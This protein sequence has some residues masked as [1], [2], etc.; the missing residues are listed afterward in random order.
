VNNKEMNHLLI[1]SYQ[2]KWQLQS[3]MFT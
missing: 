1:S 3:R 2:Q